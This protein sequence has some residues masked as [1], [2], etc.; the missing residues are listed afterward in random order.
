MATV[1]TIFPIL[2]PVDMFAVDT[3][4]P[5]Q[6]QS[7]HM[8]DYRASDTRLPWQSTGWWKQPWQKNDSVPFQ[9]ESNYGPIII[10]VVEAGTLI[11]RLEVNMAIIAQSEIEPDLFIYQAD[12]AL[13]TLAEGYYIFR[14]LFGSGREL[15]YQS[16]IQDIRV[17]H[18]DTMLLQG[19]S[20]GYYDGIT[21]DTDI[22]MKMRVPA[23]I[24]NTPKSVRTGFDDQPKNF[25]QLKAVN[26]REAMLY[27]GR[28]G[29]GIPDRF[30]DKINSF[31]GLTTLTIDGR[32][33]STP[34]DSEL[35]ILSEDWD[36]LKEYRITLREGRNRRRMTFENEVN[37]NADNH[38]LV[39]VNTKGFSENYTG[40][41]EQNILDI[42]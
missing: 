22:V 38:I 32:N 40:Q 17:T 35:E 33:Y 28:N 20:D 31:L 7:K 37:V 1:K 16:E 25:T 27:I 23:H 4:I 18:S 30:A 19:Y 3:G 29:K 5:A 42:E 39:T 26:Y 21:F 13:N 9:Y 34:G 24:A 2:C 10:Q 41:S 11:P 12:V 6:Y 36:L 14:L 8:D 15:L